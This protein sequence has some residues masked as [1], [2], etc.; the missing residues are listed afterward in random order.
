MGSH[1]TNPLQ[2]FD[3]LHLFQKLR[4]AH[5]ILEIFAV[6]VDVLAQQHDFHHAVCHEGTDLLDDLLRLP[7]PFPATHIG[8]DA[9]AAEIVA[10]KH[11]V[12]AGFKEIF[13][14]T[15]QIFHDLVGVLPDIDDHPVGNHGSVDQLGEF[16]E[17]M[18]TENQVDETVAL[19]DLLHHLRLLHHTAAEGDHHIRVVLFLMTHEAKMAVNLEICVFPDRAGVVNDKVRFLT[20]SDLIA[21]GLQNALDLLAVPCVHLT[22]QSLGA[23]HKGDG[24]V[25]CFFLFTRARSFAIK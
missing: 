23:G 19:L 16:I 17:V 3:F 21:Y 10:A 5:G 22:A 9:V 18:G 13:P 7:A 11:D 8:N 24:P 14:V 6:G 4:K 2:A 1:E 20:L 12:D 25:S 15:G